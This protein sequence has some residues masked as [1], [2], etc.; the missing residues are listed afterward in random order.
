MP[1]QLNEVFIWCRSYS[2]YVKIFALNTDD[3]AKS[4]LSCADGASSF[5]M[6]ASSLGYDI[7]SYDPIYKHAA[8][9]IKSQIERSSN[10][11]YP[12]ILK[13]RSDYNWDLFISPSNLKNHRIATMNNF[14]DD[15]SQP[16]S[17]NRYIYAELPNLPNFKLFD[18]ALVSHFLFLYSEQLSFE[19]H[20][21]SIQNL[22]KISSEIRIFP[23]LS[24]SG[25][26]SPHVGPVIE[27]FTKHNYNI[28]IEEVEYHFLKGANQMMKI[29]R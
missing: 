19:F 4:I 24:N 7:T 25:E 10:H 16:S 22:L 20:I 1:L 29:A 21:L 5:N 15:Y 6:E 8:K 12:Q 9:E 14:L 13:N 11:V 3:F 28:S 2:E 17:R 23:L 26:M 27:Y 18:L